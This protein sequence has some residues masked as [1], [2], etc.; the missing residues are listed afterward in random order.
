MPAVPGGEQAGR[1]C[2]YLGRVQPLL[3]QLLHEP[4]GEA[5]QQVPF[6]SA[7]VECVPHWA[8]GTYNH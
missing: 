2:G 3:P 4:V 6:V 8:I 7:G 5:E 1:V